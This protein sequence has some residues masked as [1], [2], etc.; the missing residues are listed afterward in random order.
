M[1]GFAFE[2][3]SPIVLSA[4]FASFALYLPPCDETGRT[5]RSSIEPGHRMNKSVLIASLL[6]GLVACSA[7]EPVAPVTVAPTSPSALW[8][9][10]ASARALRVESCPAGTPNVAPLAISITAVPVE[11]DASRANSALPASV[12]FAHGWSLTSGNENFGGLSGLETLPDGGLLSVSDAGAF[13][14]I[15]LSDSEP[16]GTGKLAYMLGPDGKQLSGKTQGDAEGL[17][18]RDAIA[19]VSFERD[20]RIEAFDLG[21]CG[22]AARAAH[23]AR[24]PFEVSGKPIDENQGAEALSILPAG[25]LKFG[26]ESLFGGPSPL[27][28]ILANGDGVLTGDMAPSPGGY[29]LVGL[30]EAVDAS[31]MPVTVTLYRSYDPIRGNRNI[32]TWST[33]DLQIELKRPMMVDNFEGVAA[34]FIDNDTLRIWLISDNNFSVRQQTLLYA[35]DVDTSAE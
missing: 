20:H 31:G 17:A 35:F 1:Y 2:I 27:G 21:E 12:T 19:L 9:F 11:L 4:H 28:I 29:S 18:L 22:A 13:V 24:L 32:V 26:L 15:G 14:W 23:V 7:P 34:E 33:S 25:T 8:S 30:D 10:E 3:Q 16:D 6:L 5:K